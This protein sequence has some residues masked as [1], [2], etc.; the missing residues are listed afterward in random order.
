[1]TCDSGV[2]SDP[3]D[4]TKSINGIRGQTV[5]AD[6]VWRLSLTIELNQNILSQ[7]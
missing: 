3:T 1:M 7:K 6:I 4:E 5:I 2:D